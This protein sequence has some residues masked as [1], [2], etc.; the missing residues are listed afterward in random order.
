[1]LESRLALY[2]TS[3]EQDAA[4]LDAL[5]RQ[6]PVAEKRVLAVQMRMHEVSAARM[7]CLAPWYPSPVS[8]ARRA[9]QLAAARAVT[10]T[11]L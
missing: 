2:K 3:P 4:A 7:S 5:S 10:C 11:V 8:R 1:M 9:A 6:S